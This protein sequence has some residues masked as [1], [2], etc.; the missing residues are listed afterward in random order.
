VNRS[1]ARPPDPARADSAVALGIRGLGKAFGGIRAMDDL[2]VDVLAGSVHAVIGPNGAGKTTLINLVTGL[3]RPDA[4][5]V[6]LFGTDVTTLPPARRAALGLARS[7]QNLQIC[8]NMSA[9]DNVMIGAHLSLDSGLLSG[10]FRLPAMRRADAACRERA[11]ALMAFVGV[12]A[13]AGAAASALP[14]G[15]LKRLEIARALAASPRLLLLDE[16]AAGLNP[17]ETAALAGVIRAIAERGTTIVLVEHDMKLVMGVSDHIL[18]LH[19]GRRLALGT[20]AEVRR[21][22]DVIE[23]YLG[24]AA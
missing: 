1:H 3:V 17:T 19:H 16:P 8:M 2:D 7:F 5:R 20:T 4:G 24:K 13:Y 18:V 11:L 14:Y 12:G 6:A 21:H 15:A 9:V 10:L 23:A 22:P